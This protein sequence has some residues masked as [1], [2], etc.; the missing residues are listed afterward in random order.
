MAAAL[1]L[2]L[3]WACGKGPGG[4]AK[5]IPREGDAQAV[6]V[7][8]AP[9][10]EAIA[11]S[12]EAEP[13]DEAEQA[14]ALAF[15]AGVRGS[16]NGETDVDLYRLSVKE[17]GVLRARLGGIE[18]VDLVLE[19]RDSEG[20][21]VVRS[22]RGPARTIEGIPNL[23]V[24]PGEYH[25]AVREFVKKRRARKG[26][27]KGS[28]EPEGRTG[29]S[30]VYELVAELDAEVAQ[31]HEVEP[32]S[33][34]DETVEVL[35][36][37]EVFGY[38]GWHQDVDM[39]KLSVE[40]F[41][42]DYSLDLDIEGVPGVTLELTLLDHGGTV[43]LERKGSQDGGLSVRNVVVVPRVPDQAGKPGRDKAAPPPR[44]YYAKLRARRSNPLDKYKLRMATR[45]MELD[46]EIEPNDDAD[47]AVALRD[48]TD[49][50]QGTRRGFLTV[51]DVDHYRITAGDE[52]VLLVLSAKPA[53]EQVDLGIEL[54]VLVAGQVV[55]KAA[56]RKQGGEQ[57]LADVR[58]DAGKTAIVKLSG[59][60]G[61]AG[62]A[63]YALRWSVEPADGA[64]LPGSDD[65]PD[66]G[67]DDEVDVLDEYDSE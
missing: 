63:A 35:I 65:G 19:L 56:G 22:D 14:N 16:L 52:P 60:G 5:K 27:K 15:G 49:V 59:K 44:Y 50:A 23:G 40:G 45:L 10:T 43:V 38:M 7:V 51:G 46:E 37:D 20:Q 3:C 30:P 25:L 2:A 29:P 39:W 53:S 36:G 57:S 4:G 11:F 9:G 1:S 58:I 42:A 21:V 12:D 32:N 48:T 26:G 66:D 47:R 62:D 34:A 24:K 54:E 18:D 31:H 64:P 8:E 6:V 33:N 41:S 28:K 67:L 61:I 13:N 55:A 17:A